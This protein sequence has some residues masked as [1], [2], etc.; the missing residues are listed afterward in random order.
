[1]LRAKRLVNIFMREVMPTR[2]MLERFG[3]GVLQWRPH[4][5]PHS[6]Q[7]ERGYELFST[8]KKRAG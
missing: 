7:L 4:T 8:G 5:L 3:S 6:K 1:M 2:M